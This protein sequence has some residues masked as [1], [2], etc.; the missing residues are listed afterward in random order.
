MTFSLLSALSDG[1]ENSARSATAEYLHNVQGA[2]T[3]RRSDRTRSF[4]RF[5]FGAGWT[6]FWRFGWKV[7]LIVFVLLSSREP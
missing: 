1:W 5:V 7:G 6:A 4:E 3:A 2:L